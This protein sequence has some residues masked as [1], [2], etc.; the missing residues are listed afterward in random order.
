MSFRDS[1]RLETAIDSARDEAASPRL[2]EE[3]KARLAQLMTVWASGYLEAVCRDAVLAYTKRRAHLTV[4]NFVSRNLNRFQN[5]KME[6]ILTLVRGIDG[7]IADDLGD[8]ADGSIRES[9]NSIVSIRHLIAH[10]RSANIS[11]G[12]VTQYF[13]DARKLARKMEDLLR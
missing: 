11:V 3:N 12:R 7:G 8:Y 1:K 13:E 6:N 10:G 4:V 2:S 9:V 5:P